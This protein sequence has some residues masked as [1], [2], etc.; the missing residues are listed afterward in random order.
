MSTLIRP[1]L[2]KRNKYWIS[3]HRYYELKHFCLQY[4]EWLQERNNLD[5]YRGRRLTDIPG[6]SRETPTEDI[7]A[8]RLGYAAWI[9]LVR[10]AAWEADPVIGNYILEGVTK[11]KS[12]EAIN[13]LTRIPCCKDVYY[14]LYRKFFYILSQ[15]RE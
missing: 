13:A 2:S 1:E 7:A 8:K 6:K 10:K 9:E 5:G 11:G 4:P 12:Y 3:R 14:D 15:M